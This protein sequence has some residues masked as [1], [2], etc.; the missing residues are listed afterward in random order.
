MTSWRLTEP[1]EQHLAK[2]MAWSEHDFGPLRAAR[3]RRLLSD[4]M[5][6]VVSDPERF[7][8][9]RIP[10]FSGIWEYELRHSKDRAP[11]EQRIRD[12]WHKLIYRPLPDG[13]VEILA[14][15][16]RSFPSGR[17]ARAAMRDAG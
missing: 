4:A 6:D 17:A 8:A 7:G 3:Y 2:I 9:T 11:R 13:T 5:D 10:R 15:V 1:A 14:I 16:G 12:P